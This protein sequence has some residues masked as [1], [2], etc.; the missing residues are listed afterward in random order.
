MVEILAQITQK[1]AQEIAQKGFDLGFDIPKDRIHPLIT[2][3]FDDIF[4]IAEIKRASPSNAHI[5]EINAPCALAGAYLNGGA[6]AISVLCEEAHFKGSLADLM[7]VKNAYPNACILRK[8]FIQYKQEVGVSYRAGADM[9]L[10]IVAMFI[11]EKN[12][13]RDFKAIYDECLKYGITPL[14]E[15]HTQ[16]EIDFIAPLKPLLV[17]VN[18]RSLHTFEID[19]ITAC[20]LRKA[21]PHSKVIFESGIHSPSS[22]FMVGSFDFDGLLCGSYLVAHENPTSAIQALKSALRLGKAQKPSF[23]QYIFALWKQREACAYKPYKPLI[24]ICGITN[25]DDALCVAGE[26]IS[27]GVD[28]LGF[29]LVKQSPRFIES[30]HIKD[31]AK[32][33]KKCYPHILCVAVVNDKHSLNEAKALYQ[34]GFIHGIQLHGL[35]KL[36]PAQFANI[37]LKEA[38][39]CFYGVQN[40]ATL[41]DFNP[42]YEGAFC[43]V[44]SQSAQGGGSGKS[45]QFDVL[46]KLKERYLCIAGGINE[47]NIKDF[48]ALCPAM[49]DINSGIESSA[50]KKD[51]HKLQALLE[52]VATICA[53]TPHTK[54]I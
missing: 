21:L 32:A 34:Q 42:H 27:G 30:R 4:L 3:H 40:I 36:E 12:G 19:I 29:I 1:K 45:I 46:S 49:L 39:F 38:L 54:H 9:L 7:V 47:K 18:A 48:L 51:K 25:L 52:S 8:D 2:P 6:S 41:E 14:V 53:P 20:T 23:Y 26:S 11:D 33:L 17:G 43:L 15:V 24:K 10:L 35:S 31:I 37:C 44:D 13:F 28:M 50:G 16:D 22:A 5:G